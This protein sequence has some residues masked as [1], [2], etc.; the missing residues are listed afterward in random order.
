VV[1]VRDVLD[2]GRLGQDC[3]RRI[4]RGQHTRRAGDVVVGEVRIRRA[5]IRRPMLVASSKKPSTELVIELMP[6]A[7]SASIRSAV[8]LYAVLPV[9]SVLFEPRVLKF[10]FTLAP[11]AVHVNARRQKVLNLQVR[12]G[13]RGAGDV[14]SGHRSGLHDAKVH[15]V[16]AT[17][18][19]E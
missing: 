18:E 19:H 1:E 3:H 10:I 11:A 9:K 16:R 8:P 5:K 6:M 4:G 15:G 13:Q 12:R 2:A 17:R 7:A 14:D